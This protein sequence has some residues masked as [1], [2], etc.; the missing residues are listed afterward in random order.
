MNIY[1]ELAMHAVQSQDELH[2]YIIKISK[3]FLHELRSGNFGKSESYFKYFIEN[4]SIPNLYSSNR[5][6]Q[7]NHSLYSFLKLL[8]ESLYKVKSQ[9]KV[10]VKIIEI[11]V[12][13][14]NSQATHKV[15]EMKKISGLL[16]FGIGLI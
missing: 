4:L 7:Y 15:E 14:Q 12:W 6:P 11:W 5:T 1:A 3:L 8:I 16:E 2:L 9:E 10:V 13:T